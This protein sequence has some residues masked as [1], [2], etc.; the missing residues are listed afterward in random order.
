MLE[1]IYKEVFMIDLERIKGLSFEELRDILE[2]NPDFSNLDL[3]GEGGTILYYAAWWSCYKLAKYLVNDL[4]VDIGKVDSDGDTVFHTAICKGIDSQNIVLLLLEAGAD[5]NQKNFLGNTPLHIATSMIAV[6]CPEQEKLKLL[7]VLLAAGANINAQNNEG[8][9]PLHIAIRAITERCSKNT[10]MVDL[11][12]EAGA[13][14]DIKNKN[15]VTPRTIRNSGGI[16]VS[17]HLKTP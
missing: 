11:L 5:V 4:K 14:Y 8:D 15:G 1:L 10:K 3:D 2:N 12:V 6:G 13:S 16:G 17:R 9:T 7:K